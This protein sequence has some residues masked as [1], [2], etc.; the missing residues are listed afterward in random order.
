MVTGGAGF[1]GSHLVDVLVAEGN[2]V[3]VIDSLI[4]GKKSNLVDV[5]DKIEFVQVDITRDDISDFFVGC[6]VVFHLAALADI[7][8]SIVDPVGY[9]TTNV[10]GTLRVLEAVRKN[11]VPR[12]VYAA[13]SSC[14]GLADEVPTKETSP[15]QPTYPYALSKWMG[16]ELVMHWGELYKID[17]LSLRLFNVYGPRA[18]T[19]GNYGAVLGVFFAQHLAELPLTVVGDGTQ[20]RDFIYVQDVVEAFVAASKCK[21]NGVSINIGASNPVSVNEVARMIGG[22]IVNIPRRPGEPDTTHADIS[23]AKRYLDWTP[24]TTFKEGMKLTIDQIQLWKDAP[25]WSAETI[26][27]ATEDWFK[28]LGTDK[29]LDKS[30]D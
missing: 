16:E 18:R 30:V 3:V 19:S 8:P 24:T 26:A 20:T 15:I 9:V 7:V 2:N 10:L 23:L 17:V 29:E 25:I 12:V 5:W 4:S 1:I 6:D 13:S 27:I 21:A 14:Y 28:F 11:K 22:Q